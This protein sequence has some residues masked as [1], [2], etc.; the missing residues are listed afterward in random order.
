LIGT[1]LTQG[2]TLNASGDAD[3]VF[4]FFDR[5]EW[6]PGGHFLAHTVTGQLG[7]TLIQGLEVI[8]YEGRV[9]RATSYDSL[10]IVTHYKATLKGRHWSMVGE[11]ERF[12][13]RFHRTGDRLE[14][15]WERR[16]GRGIWRPMTHVALTRIGM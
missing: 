11:K 3:G 1:W 8:G 15:T 4:S 16:T 2:F 5:Y 12:S 13:G 10:G 14:G 7:E 6:L 9:L